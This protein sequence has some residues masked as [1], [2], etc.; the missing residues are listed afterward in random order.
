MFKPGNPDRNLTKD[1][2]VKY[3]RWHPCCTL[4]IAVTSK[5]KQAKSQKEEPLF[6]DAIIFG[7]Q[8]ESCDN[9]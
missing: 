3:T 6:I 5:H 9:I 4:C 1:P 8:A 2:E 7:K